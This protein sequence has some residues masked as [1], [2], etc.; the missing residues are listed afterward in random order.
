M[1]PLGHDRGKLTP[2]ALES[3]LASAGSQHAAR[4]R[5]VSLAQATEL[6]TVY[7]VD[8][9]TRLCETAHRYGLLV[10]LDGARLSNAA[11]ALGV[12]LSAASLACGVDALSLGT[13]KNGTLNGEVVLLR[14]VDAELASVAGRLHKQLGQLHSKQRF[15]AA[16]VLAMLRDDRWLTNAS[17]ANASAASLARGLA[18]SGARIDYPVQTNAVFAKLDADTTHRLRSRYLLWDGPSPGELRFMSSFRTTQDDI[19]Q[20]LATASQQG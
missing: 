10:H 3:V 14:S 15:L 1:R 4:P 8:E 2:A 17:A 13:S 7:T 16:Q 20:L 18:A 6:G 11:A 19:A 12:S 9:L 5:I